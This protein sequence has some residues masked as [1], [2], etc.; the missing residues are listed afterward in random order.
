M[1]SL[2]KRVVVPNRLALIYRSGEVL[3][4]NPAINSWERIDEQTSE[5]LRWLRAGRDRTLLTDHISKRFAFT[6]EASAERTSQILAYSIFRRLLYLDQCPAEPT[7][8]YAAHSLTT[9]YWICTQACNLRCRYCYQ[10][11]TVRRPQELSTKEG[12]QLID[13]AVEAKVG[14]FIFTGGEPFTRTDLLD[15][16]QYSKNSG[17]ET[18]VITNGHFILRE[19]IDRVAES[20]SYVTV[21]LDHGLAHHHDLNR[22]KGSWLRA[23]QAIELLIEAGVHVNVNAVVSHSGM[24]DLD[25]LLKFAHGR[26]IAEL[27]IIP[28]FPMG[29]GGENTL[30]HVTP[31][32]SL[33]LNDFISLA[34][35]ELRAASTVEVSPEGT[36]NNKRIIRNHCGAGLSEVSVDP[37]G[38]VYPCKLLQY[39]EYR[40][41]NIRERNLLDIYQN[42]IKLNKIRGQVAE[43]LKPCGTCIVKNHCGG[44]CRG[45]HV[46][47]TKNYERANPLFCAY[48]RRTFEVQA[49]DN[50]GGIPGP[51]KAAFQTSL[52]AEEIHIPLETLIG[53]SKNRRLEGGL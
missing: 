4:Y 48:L 30:D 23:V 50:T 13:Q 44:G 19:N 46:S 21:S 15:L 22:G 24:S 51:R 45:I 53:S 47:F 40:T 14:T 1:D 6:G 3:A 38:W 25:E 12:H 52:S 33:R 16:A 8:R 34:K 39:P 37:E 28:K 29:R 2:L 26:N 5:V 41:D 43:T 9:V 18:N 20:F 32:D 36:Y 31:E 11:A 27:R 49:W 10:D 7:V 42:H 17:L 35:R